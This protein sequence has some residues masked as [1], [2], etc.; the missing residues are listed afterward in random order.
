MLHALPSPSPW[1]CQSPCSC[2]RR[3]HARP[4][5]T[6][7]EAV[8]KSALLSTG[9]Q[10]HRTL[11]QLRTV[12][13]RRCSRG[14]WR[15]RGRAAPAPCCGAPTWPTSSAAAAPRCLSVIV[16][17]SF[18]S[19]VKSELW[20]RRS[21]HVAGPDTTTPAATAA[22]SLVSTGVPAQQPAAATSLRA[23]QAARRVY[24]RAVHACPGAA[25]LWRDGFAS[26]G[27]SRAQCSNCRQRANADPQ[28]SLVTNGTLAARA[29]PVVHISVTI[30][31]MLVSFKQVRRCRRRRLAS[32][33][34]LRLT[35]AS[36]CARTCMR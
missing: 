34:S 25:E 12:G 9:W 23:L 31:C 27:K 1:L 22:A 4:C 8:C 19:G 28:A 24:L 3:L 10:L 17:F 36:R 5:I 18:A 29:S 21:L 11:H 33:W 30:E 2:G 26:L 7:R 14:C 20:R 35:R 16:R 6:P 13:C 15:R 32:Y